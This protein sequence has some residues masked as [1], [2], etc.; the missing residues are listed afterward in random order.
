MENR[1]SHSEY[2]EALKEAL[3]NNVY[4]CAYCK[5]TVLVM[6]AVD[7]QGKE[8]YWVG[9]CMNCATSTKP[10]INIEDVYSIFEGTF[11]AL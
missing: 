2:V 1:V 6:R 7:V 10:L 4:E 9:R 11:G 8:D 5:G 3:E